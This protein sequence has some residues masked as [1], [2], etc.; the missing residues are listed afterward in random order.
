MP[1]IVPMRAKARVIP[2]DNDAEVESSAGQRCTRG[3]ALIGG[4][5]EFSIVR[6]MGI[7]VL[8]V[9][10]LNAR[11]CYVEGEDVA[12]VRQGLSHEDR[13]ECADWVLLEATTA[14]TS[15]EL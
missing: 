7:K 6:D 5:V 2:G 12:L 13:Q 15:V 9:P 1:E 8:E 10:D 14:E 11:V 3:L 4:V